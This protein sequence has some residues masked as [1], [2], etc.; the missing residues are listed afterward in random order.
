MAP[1]VDKNQKILRKRAPIAA[2][3]NKAISEYFQ[4]KKEEQNA[5]KYVVEYY[6]IMWSIFSE[7]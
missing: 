7:F 3:T 4:S 1:R 5:I 2:D 6:F